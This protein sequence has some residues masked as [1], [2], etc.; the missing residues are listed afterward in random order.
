MTF[1]GHHVRPMAITVE[2]EPVQLGQR[3]VLQ[4]A[5]CNMLFYS[6]I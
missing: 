6:Y 3:Q 5:L 4:C 2:Q 1:S